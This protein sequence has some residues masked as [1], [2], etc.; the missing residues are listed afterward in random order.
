MAYRNLT[1]RFMSLRAATGGGGA[2]AIPI[3]DSISGSYE[4]HTKLLA[5]T[6]GGVDGDSNRVDTSAT[7]ALN[8]LPPMWIDKL[9]SIDQNTDQI[10]SKIRT[11]KIYHNKRLRITFDDTHTQDMQIQETT[12]SITEL[13]Q[14]TQR[15][16]KEVATMG[17][18]EGNKNGPLPFQER[19]IRMNVMK[20]RALK[21]QELTKTFRKAQRDYLQKLKKQDGLGNRLIDDAAGDSLPSLENID[22]GFTNE[23]LKTL[24]L[25][26]RDTDQRTKEIIQ[27]AKS[28][29]ELAQ[30]FNELNILVVE[31]GSLLD[32]IDYNIEQTLE[33]LQCASKEITKAEKYQK[34]SRTAL[35]IIVLIV[36]VFVC[37][38]I[39]IIR[40]TTK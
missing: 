34:A 30:L 10:E 6:H 1:K 18:E 38:F 29:N 23:Q 9:E 13:F 20:S 33:S 37:G 40:Q 31:Q 26:E 35:C 22:R 19:I 12:R 7:S 8:S 36:L 5:P 2:V 14:R 4:A 25:I 16:L 24:E 27:I 15:N 39:L 28:V 11:L 21:I 32:R 17:N 3:R